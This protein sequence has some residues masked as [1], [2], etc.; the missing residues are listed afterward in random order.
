MTNDKGDDSPSSPLYTFFI[1]DAIA[2]L[3]VTD[4]RFPVEKELAGTSRRRPAPSVSLPPPG[5]CSAPPSC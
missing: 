1:V 3:G 2:Y 4:V 5:C